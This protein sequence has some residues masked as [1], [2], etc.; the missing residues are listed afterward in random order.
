MKNS[1]IRVC[2]FFGRCSGFLYSIISQATA[3]P[4]ALAASQITSEAIKQR[5]RGLPGKARSL[6]GLASLLICFGGLPLL[7]L[8]QAIRFFTKFPGAY[9]S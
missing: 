2:I 4:F 9:P 5:L 6:R 8:T 3:G 1:G 7:S